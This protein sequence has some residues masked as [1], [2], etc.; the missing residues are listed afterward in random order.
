M[1]ALTAKQSLDLALDYIAMNPGRYI[2]P[3]KAGAKFP[4][5]IKNNL[6]D[7][8]ND[9]KQIT[10]WAKK[11]PGCNWGLSHKKSRVMVVDVDVKPGK[12]GQQTYDL[13]DLEYG[14][15]E[16]ET[17]RTPSGGFHLIY[18]GEHVFALGENGFGKDIDSPNYTIL[19]GCQFSDGTAYVM[20][21]A[22][23]NAAAPEWFYELIRSRKKAKFADTNAEEA[24]V[25]LDKE[26]NVEWA[27]DFLKNDAEP[28]VEGKNGDAQTVKIAM[29]LRDRGISEE[30]AAELML[31]YY[32]ERC[33]PEWE[34]DALRQKVANGY[35]YASGSA[36]GG[37]TAEAD[38]EDLAN[39]VDLEAI[40]TAAPEVIE[41]QRKEREQ[42]KTA[43]QRREPPI[44]QKRAKP[45]IISILDEYAYIA[46]I[47]RF[48]KV[49]DPKAPYLTS[50]AFDKLF[51]ELPKSGKLSDAILKSTNPATAIRKFESTG[52]VPG[53]GLSLERGKRCN[54]YRPSDVT[55]APGDVTWWNEHLEYLYPDPED[56][57]HLMNW[58]AW[59][60]QNQKRKPKHALL[61][62]GAFPGTG[63]SF[64]TRMFRL[65]LGMHNTTSVSQNVLASNF[66][67]YALNTKLLVVEELR[68]VERMSVKTALHDIITEDSISIN[69]KGLPT[70]DTDNCFG[71][72]G[73]TNDDA[74]IQLDFEDR[75]YLVL[76]TPAK[77]RESAYYA[78]LYAK[79]RDAAALSALAFHLQ[80]WDC[81]GYSAASRAPSTNA[82]DDMIEAGLS[83]LEN[84]MLDNRDKYPL[85]TAVTAIEDVLDLLPGRFAR[86]ANL[87]GSV[88][89]A[90]ER[91][92]QAKKAGQF[93]TKWGRKRLWVLNGSA[94]MA[95]EGWE[96]SIAKV[97]E[98]ARERGST[99]PDDPDPDDG[100]ELTRDE[101]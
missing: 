10:A 52:Y 66:N 21:K 72:I 48:V 62:Q 22:G 44:D 64:I 67:G 32:N 58:L 54:M 56:R 1:P 81:K 78:G 99:A 47:D 85:D 82:K 24:V 28:A 46:G 83:E 39:D 90:L 12:V 79:E 7:A 49:N 53:E 42:L 95:L 11:W 51:G 98:T 20:E 93:R 94:L 26:S 41:K 9:P 63:K 25:E 87:Y 77:P 15:P 19:A 30:K 45:T 65:V 23:P 97:Y 40:Q 35:R 59:V 33:Q 68:A 43:A 84:F 16:T 5:L 17:T 38:F 34:P 37:K 76:R 100:S 60:Y 6:A 69:Q 57:V 74:A 70:F 88:R 101:Q 80:T 71:V 50:A 31:Q 36:I 73:M 8:S 75:R 55:P 96:K 29:G 86:N 2:F 27:I 3:I 13:L 61:L 18:E 4:P 92:F 91:H 14:F 89:R